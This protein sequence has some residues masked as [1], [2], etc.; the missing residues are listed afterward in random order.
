[1]NSMTSSLTGTPVDSFRCSGNAPDFACEDGVVAAVSGGSPG[2][3]YGAKLHT[4]GTSPRRLASECLLPE[5]V[6]SDS[7]WHSCSTGLKLTGRTLTMVADAQ[8]ILR[9]TMP[10]GGRVGAVV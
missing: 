7:F 2:T 10:S 8:R 6:S 3:T 5:I 9:C 1:M 4:F